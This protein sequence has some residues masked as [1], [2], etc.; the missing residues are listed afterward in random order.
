MAGWLLSAAGITLALL[1]SLVVF[2]EL[3]NYLKE[4][5][6]SAAQDAVDQITTQLGN[7]K[8]EIVGKIADLEAQIAAGET[9]DLTALKAAAQ[10][11]D[12][13]VPDAPVDTPAEP[14]V[15][16]PVASEE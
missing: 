8:D 7:V 9:P 5:A 16:E 3:N 15:D 11:L 4:I 6:M 1:A 2:I 12:D 13:V 10:A 14:A